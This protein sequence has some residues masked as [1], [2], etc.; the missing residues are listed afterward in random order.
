[1]PQFRT[2]GKVIEA[3]HW[4]GE[5]L[6]GGAPDW[7]RAAIDVAPPGQPGNIFR[8]KDR[9]QVQTPYGEVWASPGDWILRGE[10]GGLYVAGEHTFRY[11]CE[12]VDALESVES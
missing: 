4:T 8:F 10:N 12:P 6:E 11:F 1:M 5:T 7:V 2:N 9:L 3:V